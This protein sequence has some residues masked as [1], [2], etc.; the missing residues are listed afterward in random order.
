MPKPPKAWIGVHKV[1]VL[2][3]KWFTYPKSKMAPLRRNCFKNAHKSGE[4]P[5]L[6]DFELSQSAVKDMF[7]ILGSFYNYL[8]QDEYVP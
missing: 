4:R 2:P 1:P 6:K 8:L 5:N 7:A 3:K